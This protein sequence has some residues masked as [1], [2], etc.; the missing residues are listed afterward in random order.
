M[1]RLELDE[2]PEVLRGLLLQ[3]DVEVGAAAPLVG[4][5]QQVAATGG[6]RPLPLHAFEPP[7]DLVEEDDGA[8]LLRPLEFPDR[9]RELVLDRLQLTLHR[10]RDR[11]RLGAR[12]A[13]EGEE[14]CPRQR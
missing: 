3:A 13:R 1:V 4:L 2:Q 6:Q 11:R 7:D 8:A 5:G 10:L 14:R 9:P 12:V